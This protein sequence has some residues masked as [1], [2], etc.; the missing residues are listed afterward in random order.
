VLYDLVDGQRAVAVAL[1]AY[2]PDASARI[3]AALG[4]PSSVDWAGMEYGRTR[5]VEGLEA[6][7]PLF[8]R[9]DVPE[10]AGVTAPIVDR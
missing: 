7:P 5:A 3:L 2:M 9:I 8:P 4:Q 1:A 6:A 10:P